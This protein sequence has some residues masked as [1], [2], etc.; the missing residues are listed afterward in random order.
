VLSVQVIRL[1]MMLLAA[2]P[3][4]RWLTR[5]GGTARLQE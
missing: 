2:P 4:A 5:S 3:L 1:F